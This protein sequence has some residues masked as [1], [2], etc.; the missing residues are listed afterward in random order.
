MSVSIL[1]VSILF[2]AVTSVHST[3]LDCR[4]QGRVDNNSLVAE[5]DNLTE[6]EWCGTLKKCNRNVFQRT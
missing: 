6:N 4:D 5:V 2:D 3:G 1:V